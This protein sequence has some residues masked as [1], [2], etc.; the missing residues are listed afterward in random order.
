M[1]SCKNITKAP[2]FSKRS[3]T[4]FDKR[5]D[6]SSDGV[7]FPHQP[8]YGFSRF[9]E[10]IH[11]YRRT[12]SILKAVE[13]LSFS[14]FLDVGCA[15]G[16]FPNIFSHLFGVKSYGTDFAMS[17][18]QRTGQIYG[19]T[20]AVGDALCLP[21]KDKSVDLVLCSETL[22]HVADPERVIKELKRICNKYLIITTPAAR[23]ESELNA[24]FSRLDPNL[25]FDHFHFFKEEELRR[26]LGRE[27]LIKGC[28]HRKMVKFFDL[29][30]DAEPIDDT[31]WD[32]FRFVVDSCHGLKP[33]TVNQMK[34][35]VHTMVRKKQNYL[36][37]LSRPGMIKLLLKLDHWLSKKHPEETMVFLTITP[38]HG[39]SLVRKRQSINNMLD[40]LLVENRVDPVIVS[41]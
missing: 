3:R 29:L 15:E 37:V 7:Y 39:T 30:S 40:Y 41:H 28:C 32:L 24:H 17:A 1:E 23:S 36:K 4:W 2:G 18:M 31:I 5:Y 19:I 9:A 34:K 8:I 21:F 27:T 6:F 33:E 22:E 35:H 20:G 16:Y 38:C 12:Y 14:N 25:I 26:W 13:G 10:H 11:S